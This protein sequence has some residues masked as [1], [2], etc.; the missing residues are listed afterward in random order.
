[1]KVFAAVLLC[2]L[3]FREVR[4][5]YINCRN[6][7]Q[8]TGQCM[9]WYHCQSL[10]SVWMSPGRTDSE[11]NFVQ[12]S[13]CGYHRDYQFLACCTDDTDF[14]PRIATV[15]DEESS[16]LLP[17]LN[18]CGDDTASPLILGGNETVLTE[19]SWMVLL[20]YPSGSKLDTNCAGSLINDRYV[21]TAAH[22][23]AK[24][25]PPVSV[26]LGEHDTRTPEDC[27]GKR[28]SA[29]VVTVGIEEAH[30][31]ENFRN[32][33]TSLHDI[34][35]IRLA[36]KVSYSDTIRP[37][38]LPS[39]VGAMRLTDGKLL[40]VAGWGRTLHNPTSPTKQKVPVNF[41]DFNRCR[42]KYLSL[43]IAVEPS[44]ICAGGEEHVDSCD[45]DSGGPLMSYR[46]GVWV[47][48]G[49][50]SFGR[51]CGRRGWPAIYTNVDFYDRWIKQKMRP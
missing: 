4:A 13:Q 8:K 31:H 10:Y 1:M 12:A 36:R 32:D 29:R 43:Q 9:E 28:C 3:I 30:A 46:Q 22:C 35:I 45:G 16:N 37:I 11:R 27:R 2:I 50:V 15:L 42:I 48:R 14:V 40:T 17:Q 47:L 38:C 44:Q 25:T 24:D 34:G 41:W 19:F 18:K 6:P 39:T 23:L 20:E 51:S 21:L 49:I 7:N 33:S 5:Q 26:R